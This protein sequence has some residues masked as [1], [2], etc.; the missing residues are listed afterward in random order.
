M[1]EL[2]ARLALAAD[3]FRRA[4]LPALETPGACR[5][6]VDVHVRVSKHAHYAEHFVGTCDRA[7]AATSTPMRIH[8]DVGCLEVS[9]NRPVESGS[10][11]FALVRVDR[12]GVSGQLAPRA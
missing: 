8:C 2:A 1:P 7:R 10:A 4:D 9:R 5:N 11:H 12:Q 6:V 3:S